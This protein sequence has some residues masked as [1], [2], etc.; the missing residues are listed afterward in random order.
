M[1]TGLWLLISGVVLVVLLVTYP[2]WKVVLPAKWTGA[3]T[4]AIAT[5][6][7]ATTDAVTAAAEQTLVIAGWVNGDLEYIQLVHA[8]RKRR[9]GWNQPPVTVTT[10]QPQVTLAA[11][12]ARLATIEAKLAPTTGV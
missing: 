4:N 2:K 12:A 1:G 7:D 11:I 10:A 3:V 8:C 5:A 6:S 9:D